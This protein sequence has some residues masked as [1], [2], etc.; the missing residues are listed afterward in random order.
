MS[1]FH[2]SYTQPLS[3]VCQLRL[4]PTDQRLGEG[5]AMPGL[6]SFISSAPIQPSTLP[7][8]V[9][10]Y[11]YILLELELIDW[12]SNTDMDTRGYRPPPAARH[13]HRYRDINRLR[14]I[15]ICVI[16]LSSR[17]ISLDIFICS[18][19]KPVTSSIV[20][21]KPIMYLVN[22]VTE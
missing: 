6:N 1:Q 4:R 11:Q 9:L 5:L 18:A 13:C 19:H 8:V 14:D 20:Q 3:S 10:Q 21:L 7:I 16:F 22:A 17:Y 12:M 2:T 15:F